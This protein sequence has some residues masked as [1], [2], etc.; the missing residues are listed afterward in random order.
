MRL[1]ADITSKT[2]AQR[3]HRFERKSYARY[4]FSLTRTNGIG[5]PRHLKHSYFF[6]AE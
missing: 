5:L 4:Y 3:Y 1:F 6:P 2:S